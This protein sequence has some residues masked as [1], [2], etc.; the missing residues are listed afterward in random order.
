MVLQATKKHASKATSREDV[1]HVQ[2]PLFVNSDIHTTYVDDVTWIGEL[3]LSKS[4]QNE[5]VLWRPK[6]NVYDAVKYDM[7]VAPVEGVTVLRRF[8]YP[9]ADLWFLHFG[10][11]L[12]ESVVA[13]GNK[14]GSCYVWNLELEEG[15]REGWKWG[16]YKSMDCTG[17]TPMTVRCVAVI[18]RTALLAGLD[19]GRVVLMQSGAL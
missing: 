1:V 9:H 8:K 5:L 2:I 15:A 16:G 4:T 7:E 3:I 12:S 10:L 13:V 18:S 17:G 14:K 19:D 11:N 6:G